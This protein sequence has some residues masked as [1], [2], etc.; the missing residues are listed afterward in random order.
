MQLPQKGGG[1]GQQC[2]SLDTRG[3]PRLTPAP[4]GLQ[5]GRGR[6]L[7][8]GLLLKIQF[9]RRLLKRPE[10]SRQCV[11]PPTRPAPGSLSRE[12]SQEAAILSLARLRPLSRVNSLPVLRVPP[13]GRQAGI[14]KALNP[15]LPPAQTCTLLC[16]EPTSSL[17]AHI[18]LWP[19]PSLHVTQI[20]AKASQPILRLSPR[21]ARLPTTLRPNH[22]IAFNWQGPWFHAFVFP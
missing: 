1:R 9:Q 19:L 3:R 15:P 21:Q 13:T 22:R 11:H 5:E 6:G 10:R 7:H 20:K 16:P 12:E 2:S 18:R 17:S 14:R 8:A 4:G